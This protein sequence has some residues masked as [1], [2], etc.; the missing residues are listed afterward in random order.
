MSDWR[1]GTASLSSL[2]EGE[3]E[4]SPGTAAP[5][6]R[7]VRNSPPYVARIEF[8][9][10]LL[11][12]RNELCLEVDLLMMF[13]LARDVRQR[14]ADL[15]TSDREVGT[16]RLQTNHSSGWSVTAQYLCSVAFLPREVANCAGFVHPMRGRAFDLPHGRR[17]RERRWKR[18]K[19][20]DVIV[21]SS[22][23]ESFHVVFSCDASH[24]GPQP[25]LNLWRDG[26]VPFLCGEDTM[27]KR[28]TIG[29]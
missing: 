25:R 11:Q 24:V 3:E 18:K 21:G 2:P 1:F 9:A 8:D 4:S 22:N 27:K 28:A 23:R 29:V 17:N 19:N 15:S 12:K 20:V 26:L 7:A 10:V 5:P 14:G 6:R 16:A 13:L